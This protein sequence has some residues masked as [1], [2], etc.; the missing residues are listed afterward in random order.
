M[1]I[2]IFHGHGIREDGFKKNIFDDWESAELHFADMLS[3]GFHVCGGTTDCD[4]SNRRV[5]A[6]MRPEGTL[7]TLPMELE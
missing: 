1:R 4:P 5:I 6:G 2:V 7:I 3:R